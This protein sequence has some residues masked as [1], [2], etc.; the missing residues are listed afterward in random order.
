MHAIPSLTTPLATPSVMQTASRQQTYLGR[1]CLV[2][3]VIH[4]FAFIFLS[5]QWQS[6]ALPPTGA[7]RPLAVRLQ[8]AGQPNKAFL[9][10]Q[11][12]MSGKR[13]RSS[14]EQIAPPP[15]LDFT[16]KPLDKIELST[17]QKKQ[18]LTT[19]KK[20]MPKRQEYR[21]HRS[22]PLNQPKTTIEK[23]PEPIRKLTSPA[24][25]EKAVTHEKNEPKSSL[26]HSSTSPS[27]E[28]P[29]Q[30]PTRKDHSSPQTTN[31]PARSAETPCCV[32]GNDS[33]IE[34]Y[35]RLL[36]AHLSKHYRLPPDL[37]SDASVV[38]T[39]RLKVQNSDVILQGISVQ[40]GH[41]Y[42]SLVAA[43]KA[44]AEADNMFPPLPSGVSEADIK[45]V[46]VTFLTNSIF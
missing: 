6:K 40:Q 10:P 28:K 13:N 32:K 35:K 30:T 18:L 2:S 3:A 45:R 20:E 16:T 42:A 17:R 1:S 11:T 22:A 34:Q 41:Q 14:S 39:L 27:I 31:E 24:L 7:S 8:L 37:P 44:A 9:S 33:S 29:V 19:A 15:K 12:T 5:A 38:L 26:A 4:A 43:A 23:T 21:Q 25:T 36:I 46:V